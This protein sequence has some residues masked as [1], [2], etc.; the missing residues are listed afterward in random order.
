MEDL[1]R[2]GYFSGVLDLTTTELA[3][4]LAGGVLSA[5]PERLTAAGET[6]IPQVVS[7]GALDMVNFWARDTVPERYRDRKLHAHNPQVTLMRT[8]EAE[9]AELG[10]IVA[11]KLNRAHGPTVFMMP[12]K[13]VSAMDVQGGPFHD[14]RADAA[15]LRALRANLSDRVE[16]VEVDAAI[17]DRAFAEAAAKRLVEMLAG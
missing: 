3:D 11:E 7:A 17:N 13:G 5:G 16:L 14:P 8:T 6:A 2:G 15:F 1:I 12:L 9:N 10:R 4:E